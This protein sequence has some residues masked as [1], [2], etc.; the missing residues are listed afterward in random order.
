MN[1]TGMPGV[2]HTLRLIIF[3]VFFSCI[4]GQVFGQPHS[5]I[6]TAPLQGERFTVSESIL[7]RVQTP[8]NGDSY[9]WTSNIDGNLGS[10]NLIHKKLSQGNHVISVSGE[11]GKASI[12]VRVFPNLWELYQSPLS[13][14]ELARLQKDIKFNWADGVSADEKWGTYDSAEFDTSSPNPGKTAVYA[15]FDLLRH[16]HFS[17]PLPFS[18]GKSIFEYVKNLTSRVNLK[19]NCEYNNAGGRILNLNRAFSVW[20]IRESGTAQNPNACK[21]Y[22]PR[23]A[24]SDY[25]SPLYL[26]IHETRHND[27]QDPGHIIV[28]GRQMDSSLENGSG[29]AYAALYL[30]WVYKYGI[31]DPPFI[32]GMAKRE[33]QNLLKERFRQRPSHS[34]PKVQSIIDELLGQK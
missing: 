17:E 9:S 2:F 1:L 21:N 11:G 16:Q 33:A 5:I 8:L 18:S 3:L 15:R 10:G 6:A 31:D 13:E 29:H 22:P 7:F 14:T 23:R 26:L 19:L 20:D 25:V 12:T 4:P 24:V 34:D 28:N 32:K 27:S 30:M